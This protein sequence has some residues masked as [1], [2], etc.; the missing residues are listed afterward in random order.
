MK[1]DPY[2]SPCIKIKSK[3][4]RDLNIKQ[5][6]LNLVQE[7]VRNGLEPIGIRG[8]FLSRKPVTQAL[9]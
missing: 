9:K 1:I 5:D 4:I 3:W 2:S 8:N 6:T 7:K